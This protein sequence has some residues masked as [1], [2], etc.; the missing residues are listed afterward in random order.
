MSYRSSRRLKWCLSL[1]IRDISRTLSVSRIS[2]DCYPERCHKT[3]ALK[4]INYLLKV[5][6]SLWTV[7]WG[8]PAANHKSSAPQK[9]QISMVQ[10]RLRLQCQLCHFAIIWYPHFKKMIFPIIKMDMT[11]VPLGKIL[12]LLQTQELWKIAFSRLESNLCWGRINLTIWPIFQINS[13]KS[14]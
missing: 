11:R 3:C 8:A 2:K 13:W 12:A 9:L 6:V 7:W 4:T 5:A 1:G 14:A 10:I